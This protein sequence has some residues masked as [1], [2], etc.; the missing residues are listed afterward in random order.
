IRNTAMIR[1]IFFSMAAVGLQ[2]V[3]SVYVH[4]GPSPPLAWAGRRTGG[5]RSAAL[6]IAP[7]QA[8]QRSHFGAARL[9]QRV[10]RVQRLGVL[11]TGVQPAQHFEPAGF[12]RL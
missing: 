5:G 12:D 3:L 6:W 1:E 8:P 11:G 7:P 4:H 10:G 2:R 9:V